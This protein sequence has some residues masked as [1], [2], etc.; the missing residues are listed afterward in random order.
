MMRMRVSKMMM[1]TRL[2]IMNHNRHFEQNLRKSSFSTKMGQNNPIST[3]SAKIN[4]FDQNGSKS[5]QHVIFDQNHPKSTI[6]SKWVKPIQIRHFRLKSSKNRF[7]LL[8]WVKN[9]LKSTFSTKF[10]QNRFLDKNGSKSPKVDIFHQV[11]QNRLFR[12][13]RVKIIKNR[14]F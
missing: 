7:F 12:P 10:P 5:S 4:F 1:M 13:N 6:W 9:Y 8:K 3:C 14:Y 11:T 2:T